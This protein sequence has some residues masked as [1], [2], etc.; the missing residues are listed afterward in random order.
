MRETETYALLTVDMP[1]CA[2][3]INKPCTAEGSCCHILRLK[4]LPL[5]ACSLGS[6]TKNMDKQTAQ[7]R[8]HI[9]VAAHKQ[10]WCAGKGQEEE[11]RERH[12]HGGD[13]HPGSG[14]AGGP[15]AG[16]EEGSQSAQGRHC[17]GSLLEKAEVS[18]CPCG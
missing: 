4:Q 11:S 12:G 10:V 16:P 2:E 5:T 15:P 17:L 9:L 14:G 8:R 3:N 7:L 6:E 1:S 13:L 18:S